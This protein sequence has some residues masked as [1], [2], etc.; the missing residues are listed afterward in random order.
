[1]MLVESLI[2]L[3]FLLAIIVDTTAITL[4]GIYY[5]VL[6][7]VDIFVG[8]RCLI[9]CVTYATRVGASSCYCT[10]KSMLPCIKQ[11]THNYN[12]AYL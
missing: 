8:D 9:Q 5:H 11:I 3:Y 12:I 1:M 6:C 7:S 4:H 10:V 2:K